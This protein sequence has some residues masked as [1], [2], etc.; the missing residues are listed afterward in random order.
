MRHAAAPEQFQ[1]PVGAS[2]IELGEGVIEQDERSVT[3][4]TKCSRFEQ[5]E[6]DGRGA[7]L[8]GGAET[9]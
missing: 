3:Y 8:A 1:N 4:A 2:H 6:R 9:T 5:T 7:L